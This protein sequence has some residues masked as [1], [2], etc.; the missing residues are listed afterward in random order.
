ML[1]AIIS[2]SI[3]STLI[4]L[5]VLAF[6]P[7]QGSTKEKRQSISED[8]GPIGPNVYDKD[9]SFIIFY[10]VTAFVLGVL[11]SLPS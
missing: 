11:F 1:D 10:V 9:E 3:L 4:L 7:L 8:V 2:G 6:E 5:M